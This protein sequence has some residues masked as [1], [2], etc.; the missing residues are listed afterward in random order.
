MLHWYILKFLQLA[1]VGICLSTL[2]SQTRNL[3]RFVIIMAAFHLETTSGQ[4]FAVWQSFLKTAGNS[5]TSILCVSCLFA[6]QVSILFFLL[7]SAAF[8]SRGRWWGDELHPTAVCKSHWWGEKEY[9]HTTSLSA[10][11]RRVCFIPLYVPHRQILPDMTS[12]LLFISMRR[13]FR[14]AV[15]LLWLFS[16][17]MVCISL[18][19]TSY[20]L[21]SLSLSRFFLVEFLSCCLVHSA[22]RCHDVSNHSV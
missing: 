12:N 18:T 1:N 5:Q 10:A 6:A 3:D 7:L 19:S 14:N 13:R 21:I 22:R 15:F 4:H 17:L 9:K 16:W 11:V 8:S 2:W 20:F